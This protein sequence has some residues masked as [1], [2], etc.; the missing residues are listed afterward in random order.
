[1]VVECGNL[2]EEWFVIRGYIVVNKLFVCFFMCLIFFIVCMCKDL[3][4]LLEI[5]FL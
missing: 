2:K 1:M 5:F 4:F 3:I